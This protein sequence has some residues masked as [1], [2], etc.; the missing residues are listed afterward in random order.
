MQRSLHRYNLKL[1]RIWHTSLYRA[2]T[3]PPYSYWLKS[4]PHVS[5]TT[6]GQK[7]IMTTYQQYQSIE[8]NTTIVY[9][10]THDNE[11]HWCTYLSNGI[12]SSDAMAA[13][14]LPVSTLTIH[15]HILTTELS[16]DWVQTDLNLAHLPMNS[17]TRNLKICHI[18][19]SQHTSEST[20]LT[21]VECIIDLVGPMQAAGSKHKP[22]PF[23]G[24]M[25]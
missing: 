13:F 8:N 5:I 19:T 25:S 12:K 17:V 2:S 14:S 24:Q 1:K 3:L 4:L 16:A 22:N 7:Y 18:S 6:S 11:K 20:V 9:G 23:P 10:M 15:P 21:T